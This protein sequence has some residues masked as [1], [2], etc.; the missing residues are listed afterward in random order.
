VVKGYWHE[1]G[2]GHQRIVTQLAI[3]DASTDAR[4]LVAWPQSIWMELLVYEDQ[5]LINISLTTFGKVA[6]RMPEA[7]WFSFFPVWQP[8][9]AWSLTKVDQAVDPLDVVEGGGRRM[10][11]VSEN[12]TCRCGAEE[13]HL[14]TL[15]APLAAFAPQSPLNF[16][17]ALPDPRQ[18]VHLGLY[19]NAWGTNYP[20][21]ASG[22]WRYRFSL[23]L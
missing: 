18:G 19:N 17:K 11:A 1:P 23:T 12:L 20:Q 15:D 4:K 2:P 14:R 8:G 22:D 16:S 3:E 21:W 5:P 13:L 10:H 9:Q 7:M 6:N